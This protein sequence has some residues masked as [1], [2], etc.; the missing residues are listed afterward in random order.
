VPEQ[1]IAVIGAS[2][3][4]GSALCERLFFA[5]RRDFTAFIHDAGNAARLAR[6]PLPLRMLDLLDAAQVTDALAGFPVII[7][8]S[9][10]D[11]MVRALRHLIAAAKRH[12][13]QKFVHISSTAIYGDDP[14]PGSAAETYPAEPGANEYG[15]I[16]ARQDEMVQAL[17]RTGVSTYILCPSNISGP[18]S[19]F[20]AALAR[21]MTSGPMALVDGGRYPCNLVHVD[22]LVQ[23]ILTAVASDRGSGCR[24]FVNETPA[25]T[26]H[27]YFQD[28]AELLSID[29]TFIPV[30]REKVLR[31]LSPVRARQGLIAHCK[32]AVSGE[33]RR[34]LMIMPVMQRLNDGAAALFERLP[35]DVR[36]SLRRRLQV[37][38]SISKQDDGPSLEEH[39]VR[40]Q[41]RRV[42]HSPEKL[43]VELGFRHALDYRRGLETT[44][45]W[46]RFAGL[47]RPHG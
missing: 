42:Y 29:C 45:E 32:I 15:R 22:N 36:Q 21:R 30:D 10:G 9:R 28:L 17:E 35:S 38:I 39:Y 31:R 19:P 37:P 44:A 33:F 47:G 46:L 14:A 7:N 5:G 25:V 1:N 41:V 26:W 18:Y 24:Y 12:R 16:K 43:M 2:G 40:A 34:G 13:V 23:A 27:E 4:V 11:D 6:L 8:C 20:V 3:F